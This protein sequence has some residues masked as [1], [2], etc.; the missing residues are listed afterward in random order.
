MVWWGKEGGKELHEVLQLSC[1][2]EWEEQE[3][4]VKIYTNLKQIIT[5]TSLQATGETT[6]RL[7]D[8]F[9]A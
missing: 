9:P 4:R 6:Q 2:R 1:V 8:C 5:V 3:G 7:Q